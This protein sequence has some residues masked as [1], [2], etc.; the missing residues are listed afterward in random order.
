MNFLSLFKKSKPDLTFFDERSAGTWKTNPPVLAKS[1]KTLKEFQQ[2]QYGEYKLIGCPGMHDYS[3]LGY[4]INAWTPIHFKANKAGVI[5]CTGS[6]DSARGAQHPQPKPMSIDV[7]DGMFTFEDGL[8]PNAWNVPSPWKISG[9][10]NLSVLA[11]P[12]FFHNKKINDYLYCY[13]GVVDYPDGFSP[14]NFICSVKKKCEFTIEE[15]EPL[16]QVIP[17][18]VSDIHAEYAFATEKEKSSLNTP[19]YFHVDNFYR[20]YYMIKKKFTLNKRNNE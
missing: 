17:F 11:I 3:A 5:A 12:A 6:K 13:P 15:G 2:K 1:I 7:I 10:E 9:S 4:I 18:K 16:I 8:M 14:I 20:K 19:K